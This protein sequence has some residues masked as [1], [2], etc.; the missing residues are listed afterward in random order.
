MTFTARI[1]SRCLFAA[2]VPVLLLLCTVVVILWPWW[3]H[4]RELDGRLLRVRDQITQYQRLVAT[5]P[6][7]QQELE[8]VRNRDDTKTFY[9]AAETPALAGAQLQ[10][11]VQDII[12]AS[13]ARPVSTQILPIDSNEQPPRIRVRIQFQ[14]SIESLLNVLYRIESA[15]PFLFIDQMSL[16]SSASNVPKRTV[17]SRRGGDATPPRERDELTLRLDLFGFSLGTNPST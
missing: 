4:S 8:L 12:R 13:G 9:F 2:G 10:S 14:G 3:Q 6:R 1:K 5:L 15:R 7:L 17:R 11:E 16:R